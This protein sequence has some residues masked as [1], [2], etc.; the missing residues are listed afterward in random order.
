[1]NYIH[2][3]ETMLNRDNRFDLDLAEGQLGEL[4][5]LSLASERCKIEVKTEIDIW[6]RTGNIYIEYESR[7]KA[8]GLSVTESNYW[9][10]NLYKEDEG[11]STIVLQTKKLKKNLKRLVKEGK[12]NKGV[13]GGDDMT[14]RGILFPLTLL[15]E[16]FK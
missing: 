12:I 11:Y 3:K 14:S 1:M 16:L 6:S 4:H 10:I 7:G 2:T 13:K 15:H 8:S 9:A 5:F